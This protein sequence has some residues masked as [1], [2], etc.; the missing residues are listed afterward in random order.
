VL[1]LAD[2]VHRVT[3]PLPWALDHVH[4]YAVDDADGWTLIDC[5]LG[6]PGTGRR[7]EQALAQLGH[8]H[9]RRLVITHYHPDHIGASTRLAELTGAEEIVQGRRDRELTVHT[10][11]DS[12]SGDRFQRYLLTHGMPREA[13][14]RSAGE[15]DELPIAPVE[16]TRLVDEGDTLDLA[17]ET[18]DVLVL[19]GHADGHIALLGRRSGRLF[20]GDVLLDEITPNVGRWDDNEPDPLGRYLETLG[21]IEELAPAVVYPGHRGVIERPAA[22]AQE[23][24]VHHVVRLDEHERALRA[25]ARSAYDVAQHVWGGKL[26]FHEQRFALAE[27]LAHIERLERQGRAVEDEPNRWR[28][29]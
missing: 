26:G 1:E 21:R 12:D 29:A 20:G 19:P 3:Q 16:P 15:E 4:C 7:W 2:G 5:G 6:T 14:E 27:A 24:A 23:I 17:G 8:P 10:W 11:L 13:A 28:A 22:R 9:V 25:G 18:F